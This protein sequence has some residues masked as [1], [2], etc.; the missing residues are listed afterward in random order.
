M[1]FG[2]YFGSVGR[3]AVSPEV[4]HFL[5]EF[6]NYLVSLVVF[7]VMCANNLI[8]GFIANTIISRSQG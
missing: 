2:L 6:W 1:V 8:V 4:E 5:H 7:V 3:T